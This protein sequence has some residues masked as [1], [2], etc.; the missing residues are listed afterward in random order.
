MYACV[1]TG[2]RIQADARATVIV[3][4]PSW[5]E[6][7]PNVEKLYVAPGQPFKLTCTGHGDPQPDIKW[8]R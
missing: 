3:E 6:I 4:S 5:V 2:V 8:I 7:T 1:Y